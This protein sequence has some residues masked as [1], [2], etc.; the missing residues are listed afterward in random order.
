[1]LLFEVCGATILQ[2][3]PEM[4]KSDI[5]P[6]SGCLLRRGKIIATVN[7][8]KPFRSFV[9][10]LLLAFSLE[11]PITALDE[12]VVRQNWNAMMEF[13]D[14]IKRFSSLS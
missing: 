7:L 5:Q 9:S 11:H 8:C 12:T 6:F 4:A 1:M 2:A 10:N 13:K 14:D 3:E